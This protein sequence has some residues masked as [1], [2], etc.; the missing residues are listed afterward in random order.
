MPLADSSYPLLNLFWT[1]FEFFL[2]VCRPPRLTSRPPPDHA[3]TGS[4][5][6]PTGSDL[7]IDR[8]RILGREARS[9]RLS[10]APYAHF[11]YSHGPG[12]RL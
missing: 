6:P 9:M 1:M 3:R 11:P 5:V 10:D 7:A 2:W 8:Q 4:S 12:R